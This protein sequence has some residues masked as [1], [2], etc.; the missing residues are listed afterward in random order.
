LS[1]IGQVID[2][3]QPHT[4][5]NKVANRKATRFFLFWFPL[6][7]VVLYG[8]GTLLMNAFASDAFTF[9]CYFGMALCTV[10]S[11]ISF[12]ITEW[13]IDLPNE[14]F[15]G[16]AFG[17]IVVRIFTLLFAFAIGQFVFKMDS[18]GMA[19]GMFATYFS[20]L[21]IEIAYIHKK[22]LKRGH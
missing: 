21:V 11:V 19:F 22:S 18:M 6:V 17:S 14:A 16:V 13:A 8:G 2:L 20:Y 10:S 7:S 1:A 4:Q 5:S 9:A 12:F 15:F 3:I